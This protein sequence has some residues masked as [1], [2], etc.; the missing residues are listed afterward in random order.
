MPRPAMT[1]ARQFPV[2]A[3]ASGVASRERSP[4][5]RESR[6]H[7]SAPRTSP[8]SVPTRSG[9]LRPRAKRL[10]S[11][12]LSQDKPAETIRGRKIALLGGDDVDANLLGAVKDALTAE[13]AIFEF[14]E[15]HAGT[16]ADSAGKAQKVNRAA[17]NAPS[18]VYDGVVVLAARPPS[19]SQNRA[20]RCISVY[21]SRFARWGTALRR[22]CHRRP[23][24]CR[25]NREVCRCSQAASIPAPSDCRG[26]CLS[27]PHPVHDRLISFAAMPV[28]IGLS[29]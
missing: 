23:R 6:C 12:A 2:V 21:A 16:I 3:A 10:S 9:P 29:E 1:S 5:K 26:A 8:P 17:P 25:C 11:P 27:R 13:G 24:R 19:P 14:I 4:S 7:P 22:K 15:A 18:V 28:G 20:W